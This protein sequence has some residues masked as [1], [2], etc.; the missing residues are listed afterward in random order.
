M[1]ARDLQDSF[2]DRDQH[3]ASRSRRLVTN[4]QG[5]SRTHQLGRVDG[6]PLK[7]PF[8]ADGK[9]RRAVGQGTGVNLPGV[10]RAQE[11]NSDIA[12]ALE[13][14]RNLDLL[15]RLGSRGLE[16]LR[17]IDVVALDSNQS[18]AD[19]GRL[20]FELSFFARSV[21]GLAELDLEFGFALEAAG[22]V[23]MAD[24]LE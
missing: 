9:W 7:V 19:I 16:P 20:D 8:A 15:Y 3:Q 5:I 21:L 11:R 13:L 14:F 18:C 10:Q 1:I 24:H 4:R 2:I 23:G 12:V 17:V 22:N 6:H